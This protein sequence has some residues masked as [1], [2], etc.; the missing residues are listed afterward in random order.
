MFALSSVLSSCRFLPV[1]VLTLTAIFS[2]ICRAEEAAKSNGR[3][4]FKREWLPRDTRSLKGDGLG[5]MFNDTSCVACH[6]QGGIGGGGSAAKNVQIVSAFSNRPEVRVPPANALGV[7]ELIFGGPSTAQKPVETPATPKLTREERIQAERKDLAKNHPGFATANSI[8]LHRFSTDGEY[9]A[10]RRKLTGLGALEDFEQQRSEI[11]VRGNSGGHNIGEFTLLVSERN[12]PALFGSGLIDSI[13]DKVIVA[14]AEKRFREY[15]QVAGRVAK[16]KDGRIGRFGWKGQKASLEDFV[17]AACAVE[18][19]LEV[20]GSQQSGIPH[21]AEY[22]APGLDL[23]EKECRTLTEFVARLPRPQETAPANKEEAEYLAEGQRL[24]EQVGC[25]VCHRPELGE[26]KGIYTDLLLHDM[27]ADLTDSGSY[28]SFVP[29]PTE[30]D[31]MKQPVPALTSKSQFDDPVDKSKLTVATRNEWRTPPLWGVRD[32]AP[33][34][35]DGRA[36]TLEQAVALHGGEA[37]RSSRQFQNLSEA[38]RWKITLFLRT[39]TA[40]E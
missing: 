24:F 25:A 2:S 26:V 22:K 29:N 8:V 33:Y 19:G 27:G 3:E 5:P 32:S 9:T 34:L 10:Y 12:A 15:P 18:L 40:P 13:P 7:L 17:L 36:A 37:I 20:P 39:L 6:N 4:L 28:G 35:H 21:V 1:F 16:L 30:D 31:D 23:G 38:E 14:A 11:L